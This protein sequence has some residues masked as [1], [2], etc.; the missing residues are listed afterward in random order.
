MGKRGPKPRPKKES[1]LL[2]FP[3]KRKGQHLEDALPAKQS[4]IH[5]LRPAWL[6]DIAGATDVWAELTKAMSYRLEPQDIP[7]FSDLCVCI[8]RLNSDRPVVRP[9]MSRFIALDAKCCAS[10]PS[11]P[12]SRPT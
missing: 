1:A 9:M 3:G 6:A 12:W 10:C 4:N 8:A 5:I 7:A 2:G 11:T